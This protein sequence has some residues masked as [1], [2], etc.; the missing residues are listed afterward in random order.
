MTARHVDL[1]LAAG[2]T[3]NLGIRYHQAGA[4][5]LLGDVVPGDWL[6]YQDD[7]WPVH[8]A[9]VE[10][11]GAVRLRL[12]RG[13]YWEPD[14]RA[15]PDTTALEA[16]PA[17]LVDAEVVYRSADG[18]WQPVP[19][20]LAAG[21][22]ELRVLPPDAASA[23]FTTALAAAAEV[24]GPVSHEWEAAATIGGRRVRLAEGAFMFVPSTVRV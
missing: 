24:G 13:Q 16:T 19:F 11:D 23:A 9:T 3:P 12:G 8:S 21:D 18:T 10:P 22:T 15:R 1:M 5:W 17:V 4:T 20:G 2:E 6:F 7:P 14:V